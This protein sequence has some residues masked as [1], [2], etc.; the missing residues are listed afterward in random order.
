MPRKRDAVIYPVCEQYVYNPKT[1]EME[2]YF[3]TG[4]R[5][6]TSFFFFG[7]TQH[8]SEL[9][10]VVFSFEDDVD[11][12]LHQKLPSFEVP[13]KLVYGIFFFFTFTLIFIFAFIFLIF[14]FTTTRS[15]MIADVNPCP[16]F[17]K[18][19]SQSKHVL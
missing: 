12:S 2:F 10:V 3:D 5:Y 14:T 11:F 7:Y 1:L 6:V 15:Y 8:N 4:F 19:Y 9:F 16:L 13:N 18:R 17:L